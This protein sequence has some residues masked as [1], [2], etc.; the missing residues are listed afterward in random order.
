MSRKMKIRTDHPDDEPA[1][2]SWLDDTDPHG[3]WDGASLD[4]ADNDDAFAEVIDI[5]GDLPDERETLVYMGRVTE[6]SSI[7]LATLG[8]WA[9]GEA[10]SRVQ[11]EDAPAWRPAPAEARGVPHGLPGQQPAPPLP[12]GP[13][14]ARPGHSSRCG[15]RSR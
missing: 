8:T 6:V 15:R 9:E 5:A 11:A 7:E 14:H 3:F 12:V 10:C 4:D 2:E 1:S 13:E